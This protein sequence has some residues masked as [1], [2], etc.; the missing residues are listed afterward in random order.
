MSDL[1]DEHDIDAEIGTKNKIPLM[2]QLNSPDDK[3]NVAGILT[4]EAEWVL[5]KND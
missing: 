2:I 5:D 1:L 4:I 3:D